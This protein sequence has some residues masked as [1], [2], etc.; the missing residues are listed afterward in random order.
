MSRSRAR[1]GGWVALAGGLALAVHAAPSLAVPGR[2]F[3]GVVTRLPGA[4][5]AVALTFDDG[6]HPD[7]TPAVLE[8]LAH[9]GARAT[10]FVV[11]EAVRRYPGLAADILSAGHEVALH[12]DR[13]LPHAL[14]PPRVVSRDLARAQAEVED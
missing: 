2:R 8:A 4:P 5:R 12:G 11:G 10:F 3:P 1:S 9:A 14:M 13:H 6:P 7:G